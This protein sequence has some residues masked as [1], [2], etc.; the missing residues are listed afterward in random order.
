MMPA[1]NNKGGQCSTPGPT[2][3]CKT[4]SPGGPVPAPY[5]NIASV[6]Q[7]ISGTCASRVKFCNGKVV[8]KK[9][10]I[11]MSSGDEG[12]V[13]G[14]GVKSNQIKGSCKY[15]KGSSKV[16]V[17]GQPVVYVSCLIA[18]NGNNAN[19][20]AGAQVAPSQTKVKV[21]A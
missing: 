4:P 15:K 12:G 5:P 8:T 14:G 9:T 19:M 17:E 2:D 18:Q 11:S 13:A 16:K 7:A 10:Q 20:P 1:S 21:G 3:V 6:A